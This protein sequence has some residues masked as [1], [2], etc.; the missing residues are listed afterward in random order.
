M[1]SWVHHNQAAFERDVL[2][3]FC[4]AAAQLSE[5]FARFTATG[6]LSFSVL[7]SM[8][9]E[10][11]NKGLLWRLKDK[12][13]H[14]FLNQHETRPTGL[15]LDWTLGSVFHESLKLME[16]AHQRQ[17]YAPRLENLTDFGHCPE[18]AE[19][20]SALRDIQSQTV[21]SM[22]RE[23][24]R[25]ESLLLHS[26]KLF[27]LY[28]AGCADHRPLARFL[29]DSNTLARAIFADD[30]ERL[31]R[32]IYG[33]EPERMEVE[34]AYSLLESARF[35]AASLAVEAALARNPRSPAAL[36]LREIVGVQG[37]N[38]AHTTTAPRCEH[39]AALS[40]NSE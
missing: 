15:L 26:R 20:L 35:A 30:Y 12:A 8:I 39:S 6:I 25:L 23:V 19:R 36:S 17:H 21:E 31:I 32:S 11:F 37:A 33:D 7:R 38:A 14:I 24:A 3:D 40:H 10:P 16:D 5:Q 4:Q 27:C 9:G 22:R 2:R 18:L 13:H 34:A 29:H 1:K 28:F